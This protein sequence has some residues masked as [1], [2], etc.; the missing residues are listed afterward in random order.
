IVEASLGKFVDENKTQL[1]KDKGLPIEGC[2]AVAGR[3]DKGVTAL[4]Q[5][6]SF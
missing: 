1:L 6:C 2:A 5:V 4:Q 3:T